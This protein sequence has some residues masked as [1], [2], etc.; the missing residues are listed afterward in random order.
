M[1]AADAPAFASAAVPVRRIAF[2]R[3]LAWLA[4]GWRD[5]WHGPGVSLFWGLVASAGGLAIFAVTTRLP[6]LFPAAVSGFMLVA[7]LLGTSLYELSRRYEHGEPAGFVQSLAVW[8]RK[9]PAMIGFGLMLLIAGTA[10][11]VVSV[12]MVAL[13]YKGGALAPLDLV[14]EVVLNPANASFFLGYVLVGGVLAAFVFA[15]SVISMP[16]LVDRDCGVSAALSTSISAVSENPVPMV[17]WAICIMCLAGIG[18]VTAFLGLVVILP[19]LGHASWHAY[20][21]LTR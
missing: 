6:W 2:S 10:W 9:S 1:V 14:L 19:W 8:R 15:L 5:L 13:L 16:M 18:L 17:F 7:P 12:V 20:R 3:P 4:A 21:D 11:Q